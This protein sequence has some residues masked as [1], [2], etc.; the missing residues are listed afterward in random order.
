MARQRTV[1]ARTA[2][3]ATS[4]P[5]APDPGGEPE[6]LALTC[7]FEAP[8]GTPDAVTVRFTGRRVGVRGRPQPADRFV[9]DETVQG[10]VPGS[11]RVSV[12]TWVYGL[13]PGEWSVAAELVEPTGSGGRPAGKGRGARPAVSLASWSWRRWTLVDPPEGPVRTRSAPL[14]RLARMPAVV[15]GSWAGLVAL[16]ALVAVLVQ[17]LLLAGRGLPVGRALL[18]D[19]LAILAGLVGAKLWYI[20]LNPRTWRTSINVGWCIQGFLVAVP[21]VAGLLLWAFGLP[22]GQ[23]LDLTTPGVFF[24]VAIGRVGCFLTGCCAGRC[25]RSRWGI[26]SSDRRVGA[27]RIPTQLGESLAGL[28]LAVVTLPLVVGYRPAVPGGIFVAAFAAYTLVRQALLRLRAEP[29]RSTV[30]A[31][32]TAALAS[33][34]LLADIL[35]LAW[36]R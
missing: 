31:P 22:V 8:E 7:S 25:T 3:T 19:G 20:A 36:P 2:A 17:V 14:V 33:L 4:A 1:A 11:G 13:I 21:L 32:L 27:R 29:R 34:V 24:G 30:G 12:T 35:V 18:V 16:G 5:T 26:W 28:V 10:V 15:P 9:Q 6:A 23:F